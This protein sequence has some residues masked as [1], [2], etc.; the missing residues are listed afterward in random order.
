V[1]TEPVTTFG[2]VTVVSGLPRS[3]TSMMMR[4]LEAGGLPVLADGLRQPDEDNP[5]GYFELESVKRTVRDPTWLGQAGG[6]VVKVIARLLV[7]LPAGQPYKIIFMRR[8]LDEV[9]RSQRKMLERRGEPSGPPDEEMRR[10]LLVHVLETED[11]LRTRPEMETL[12]VSYNR[13][14]ADPRPQAERI[15]R[16]LGGAL[17]VDRMVGAVD[18]ALYRQRRA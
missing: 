12:Y 6:K 4:V 14:V 18:A 9:L 3:G 7:D 5:H 13:T 8:D 10:L 1:T 15:N 17:D 16:F 2:I 11:F